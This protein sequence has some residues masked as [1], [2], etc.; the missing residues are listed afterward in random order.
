MASKKIEPIQTAKK[1]ALYMRRRAS[2]VTSR[3]N[4]INVLTNAWDANQ[5]PR[6]DPPTYEDNTFHYATKV[7]NLAWLCVSSFSPHSRPLSFERGLMM[8]YSLDSDLAEQRIPCRKSTSSYSLQ[9][10]TRSLD[11]TITPLTQ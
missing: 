10:P 5:A 6:I 11:R 3:G 8:Q 7:L 1:N 9:K 2:P 4:T